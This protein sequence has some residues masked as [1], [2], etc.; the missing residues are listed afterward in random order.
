MYKTYIYIYTHI[1]TNSIQAPPR[2]SAGRAPT[3]PPAA[4]LSRGR[5]MWPAL[6]SSLWLLLLLVLVLLSVLSLLLLLLLLLSLFAVVTY[7][8]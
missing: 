4:G 6:L 7:Q 3:A 1:H 5:A 8:Y 2:A